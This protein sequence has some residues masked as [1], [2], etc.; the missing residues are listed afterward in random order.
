MIYHIV[1]VI[2]FLLGLYT[3]LTDK[4]L[5]KMVIGLNIMEAGVFFWVIA[6]SNKGGM[7]PIYN[8]EILQETVFMNDP[9]PQALIL[10]GIVIGASTSAYLLTLIIEIHKLTD[11][12][13]IDE[14][15][16]LNE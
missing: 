14:L 16:G 13:E 10:T 2:L 1:F 5:I 9:V 4:N 6:I 15:K 11:T 3:V 8:T 7:M 12:I